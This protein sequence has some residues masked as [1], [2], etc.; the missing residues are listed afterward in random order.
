MG[1]I[2]GYG[3]CDGSS[4]KGN[5]LRWMPS[6]QGGISHLGRDIENISQTL[7]QAVIEKEKTQYLRQ[8]WYNNLSKQ[9]NK[10]KNGQFTRCIERTLQAARFYLP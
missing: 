9:K 7:L 4:A 3:R 2:L 1:Q 10:E 5:S 8:F 6:G